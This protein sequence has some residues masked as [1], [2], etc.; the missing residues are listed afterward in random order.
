MNKIKKIL[1]WLFIWTSLISG[2]LVMAQSNDLNDIFND[3]GW[4]MWNST[5]SSTVDTKAKYDLLKQVL[6]FLGIQVDYDVA[7]NFNPLFYADKLKNIAG[8]E[9]VFEIMTK[10]SM[11]KANETL[12][13]TPIAL[14]GTMILIFTFLYILLNLKVGVQMNE[15]ERW[16]H[17][18]MSGMGMGGMG[19]WWMGM[20]MWSTTTT[21]KANETTIRVKDVFSKIYNIVK[22]NEV[23]AETKKIAKLLLIGA[24][25][26]I[27]VTLF[28]GS[29]S[30]DYALT[31]AKNFKILYYTI[32]SVIIAGIFYMSIFYYTKFLLPPIVAF[33]MWGGSEE[34]L[35]VNV[36]IKWIIWLV[37]IPILWGVIAV[38][39]NILWSV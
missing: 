24:I 4:D 22:S 15:A 35:L 21:D 39:V 11:N 36:I 3:L 13:I 10:I 8:T 5:V 38:V 7:I 14:I 27:V 31:E 12:W 9:N 17:A 1:L 34:N 2:S 25:W 23:D 33:A 28:L 18:N 6:G 19:M 32:A 29:A 26:F 30:F 37:G 16:N 20:G